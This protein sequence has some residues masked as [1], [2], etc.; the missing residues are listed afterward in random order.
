MWI[1]AARDLSN[2]MAVCFCTQA[3]H[4]PYRR[5]ARMLC[6]DT[7]P[8]P[9]VVL[10][11]EPADF[12]D[13]PVRAIPRAPTG[14]TAIDYL[15]HLAPTVGAAAYHDKRLAL[16]AALQDFDTAI[17]L[18]ADSRLDVLPVIDAFPAGLAVTPIVRESIAVH[19]KT[20]GTWRLPA[21]DALARDLMEDPDV[22]HTADVSPRSCALSLAVH[23]ALL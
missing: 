6:A 13:L 9:W 21:L 17:F 18:D 14:P 20:C 11:E 5:R 4:A 15:Q 8:V 7:A 3:I 12:A 16:Q 23:G 10:T 1:F 2:P 19:L 22:L